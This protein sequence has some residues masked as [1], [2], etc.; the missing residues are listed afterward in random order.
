MNKENFKVV[1]VNDFTSKEYEDMRKLYNDDKYL[2]NH[3][4]FSKKF[5]QSN[6][7]AIGKLDDVIIS[8]LIV[9]IHLDYKDYFLLMDLCILDEYN[10]SGYKKQ[11]IRETLPIIAKMDCKKVGT[12]IGKDDTEFIDFGF[13]EKANINIFGNEKKNIVSAYDDPYYELIIE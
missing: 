4:K 8:S 3:I 13:K 2:D 6:F 1:I 10:N 12:F 7:F 9:D 5:N 11:L